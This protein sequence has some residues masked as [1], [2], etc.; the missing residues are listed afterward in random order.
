MK[1]FLNI[2]IL[3]MIFFSRNI[4]AEST[5]DLFSAEW[6]KIKDAKTSVSADFPYEPI[7]MNFDTPFQNTPSK[8][9]ICIYSAPTLHGLLGLSIF[10]SPELEFER[11]NK[12][13]IQQ[14]VE[15]LLIPHFFFDPAP[16]QQHC[17]SHFQPMVLKGQE[18]VFFQ[19]SFQYQEV[20]KKIEGLLWSGIT[21]FA[22]LSMW[23]RKKNLM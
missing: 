16:F 3:S 9:K 12:E 7:Q 18:A 6:V 1:K 20:V 17:T 4:V 15:K 21:F 19:F 10:Y 23:L 5:D 13:K 11:W 8:G 2:F 14:Y 22:S